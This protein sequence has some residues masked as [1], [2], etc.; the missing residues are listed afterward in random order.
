MDENFLL[1]TQTAQT[2][3]HTYAKPMPI[4]DFHNHLSA[5]E[6]YE[7]K[8]FTGITQAW[9]AFDHYK[10][11]AER[12]NGVSEH[13]ITGNASDYE[14]FE[15][16]AATMPYL[17]GNP[18][19]HWTHLE[20][21]RFFGIHE[22]LTSTNAKRIYDAC[23][24]K[25]QTKEFRVRNLIKKSNVV[26]LCTTDDPCDELN[27]HKA[28]KKENFDV[29]VLPTF[30]A[31]KAIHIEKDTFVPYI[32]QLAKV[33]GYGITSYKTFAQA[34]LER[35]EYFHEVGG[36]LADH[37]LDEILYEDATDTEIEV[38]YHNAL[39]GERLS[40]PDISKFQ[41]AIQ[42]T[43]GKKYN[44]LGWVLQLHIGPMRNN[45]TRRF[46]E[47]GSD[48]GFDSMMDANVAQGLAALLDS[49][50][51]TNELPRTILYC[52]NA[53][54]NDVLSTMLGNFQDG[55]IPGKLQFGP[56]WWFNDHK[57]GM[58]KHMET[59][60]ATG[61]LSRFIGMLTDSRSFLS[62]PR[63]E[64]FRRLLCN[65]IGNIVE[66]GEYPNDMD[67]LGNMIQDI[68]YRNACNYIKIDKK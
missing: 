51:K 31:D 12:S 6:I 3:Y 5:Q 64:Y 17:L 66:Q 7:D 39:C 45:A 9:L 23:N 62:F 30:R 14:K 57:V 16:W 60:S 47:L 1:E 18:L 34:M 46:H 44:E 4:F 21:Q 48:A 20:L 61:L 49:M 25:I 56:A 38:I 11:R 27:Y 36:R 58:I 22:P 68:C 59:L 35:V 26:A 10:W 29:H 28:L 19:Y 55:K 41:G 15:H 52:L 2:L 33:V 8:Q 50:D 67:F 40:K 13:F 42:R 53:K 65:Y 63:H 32:A 54:D 43:L 37:G 24:E